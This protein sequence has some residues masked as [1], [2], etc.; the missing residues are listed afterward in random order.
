L[1]INKKFTSKVLIMDKRIKGLWNSGQAIVCGWLLLPDSLTAEI[2]ANQGYDIVT[3]D[4][5]HGLI[6]YQTAV[7]MLQ[8]MNGSSTVPFARVPWLDPAIIMKLLDAGILGIICPMTNTADEARRLASYVRYPPVGERSFGPARAGFIVD[9]DYGGKA[10]D[11][12]KCLAMIETAEG[13]RNVEEIVQVEGIDGVYIGP[14][15]LTLGLYGN[16]LPIGIDREEPEMIEA[17]KKILNSA[18]AAGKKAGIHCGTPEYAARMTDLGFDMVALSTDLS[19]FS[20]ASKSS[21][22]ATRR[23]M[24]GDSTESGQS[25]PSGNFL[26]S[27]R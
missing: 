24:S 15:D 11:M 12:V 7:S 14:I 5:Q 1:T 8:A 4:L 23:L 9:P 3:I 16:D 21:L 10:N 2:M 20:A 26:S 6:D 13:Y 22:E 27:A 25:T 18:H 17:I 19:L